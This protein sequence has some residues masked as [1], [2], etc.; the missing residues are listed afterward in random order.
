MRFPHMKNFQAENLWDDKSMNKLMGFFELQ[1]MSL[2]AIPWREY[3]GR[4]QLGEELL[5]TVRS[6]VFCGDDFNLPRLV[7]AEAK[8]AKTFADQL[9]HELEGKGMVVFYPYFVANK[10]GTL[11]VRKDSTIIEAVKDD[12]WNLVTLSDREV[13]IRIENAEETVNGNSS[14]LSNREKERLLFHTVEVKRT[15]RDDLLE[16]KS[17]LLEWSFARNCD[18]KRRPT[19][20]EYLVFYEARTV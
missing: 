18:V 17:I 20:E 8:E 7:G 10:S 12:L 3:T 11:E 4:E 9:L 19:G 2:P 5:W 1:S 6:A 13:T 15:F 16:G 14:F